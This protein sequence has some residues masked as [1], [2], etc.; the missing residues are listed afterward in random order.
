MKQT[1]LFEYSTNK[2]LL[3]SLPPLPKVILTASICILAAAL[4]GFMLFIPVSIAAVLLAVSGRAV[5]IQL[6]RYWKLLIFFVLTGAV[7]FITSGSLYIGIIFSLR[8]ILMMSAG[9][10]FYSTTR[11]TAFRTAGYNRRR[12]SAISNAIDIIVMTLA[13]LPAVFRTIEQMRAAR[14]SRC[15]KAGKN[16]VRTISLYSIPLMISMF[17]EADSAA[18]AWYSR[19][20]SPG[21]K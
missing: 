10:I 13:F 4:N 3:H 19:G 2:T 1:A 17:L 21:K 8:M 11:L 6:A 15:F 16:P 12:P 14:Y 7:R 9:I 18:D 20:Y 5:I